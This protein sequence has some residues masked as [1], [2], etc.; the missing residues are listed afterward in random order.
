MDC[1]LKLPILKA[2]KRFFSLNH[3]GDNNDNWGLVSDVSVTGAQ[4]IVTLRS[5]VQVYNHFNQPIDVYYMTNRGNE[6][7]SIRSIPPRSHLNL[8]LPTIYT[9]TNELFFAVENHAVTNKAYIWKDLQQNLTDIK[10]LQCPPINFGGETFI[11]K[12]KYLFT[13][14]F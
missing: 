3:K 10:I 8:P 1:K 12:V 14:I 9:M 5:M 6:I 2:D 13:I 4:T 7:E 11:I